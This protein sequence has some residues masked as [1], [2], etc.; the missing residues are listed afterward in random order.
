MF[1]KANPEQGFIKMSMYG[2][3]GSG[4]TLTALMFAEFLSGNKRIAVVDTERGTDFYVKDVKA[5]SV[6]PSGFDVDCL[7]SRSIADVMD[8]VTGLDFKKYSVI[9]IDSISHL[10]DA[11]IDAYE[12]KLTSQDTIPMQAWGKIKKPY[13]VL[14]RFLMDAPCHVFILGRQKNIFED[15][16][17]K[18]KKTGVGMR[19]EGETEY[20]PHLCARMESRKSE[21]DSSKFN[22]VAIFEKDRTGILAGRSYANPKSDLLAPIL[23]LL[24]DKQAQSE[25]PDEVMAKDSEL[26]SMQ[27]EKKRSKQDKSKILFSE[28]A[29]KV[30]A[31]LSADEL[32]AVA[33][34]IKKQKRYLSEEHIASLTELYKSNRDGLVAKM[35]KP[36]I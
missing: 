25:D 12:G 19:A 30:T 27:D 26:L 21:H 35:V 5:R 4:K 22:V 29:G 36:E 6:H 7:Y 9:V 3:P 11:A 16:G 1:K 34:E 31:C 32:N 18:L 20:E 2:P 23:P 24:G 8:A 10:W 15:D 33:G 14:I 13:K 17:E 28:M